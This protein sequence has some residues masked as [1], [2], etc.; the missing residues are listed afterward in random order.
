MVQIDWS[1]Y[2]FL[3]VN[4]VFFYRIMVNYFV[5]TSEKVLPLGF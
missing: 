2:L 3:M 4:Y 1:Y 5:E